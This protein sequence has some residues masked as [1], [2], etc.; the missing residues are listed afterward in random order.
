MKTIILV[1][2]IAVAACAKPGGGPLKYTFDNAKIASVP[3]DAKQSVTQAQQAHDEAVLLKQRASDGKR[4]SE[5]EADVAEYQAKR[6]QLVSQVV[7]L[8]VMEKPAQPSAE[9]AALARRAAEAKV[10]FARARHAWLEHLA[11]SSLFAAYAAQAK[12]ELERAKVAQANNLAPAG[13]D[14]NVFQQQAEKRAAAAARETAESTRLRGVA[15][16]RLA[17]WNELERGFMQ[18]SALVGPLESERVMLELKQW[19]QRPGAA[20]GL[21]ARDAM[22][23]SAAAPAPEGASPPE[24]ASPPQ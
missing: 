14:I 15:D 23:E 4:D 3:L 11:S 16:T 1:S 6:A 2:T 13:F 24:A 10:G 20:P 22:K 5:I 19:D 21:T 9:A 18:A 7:A 12:L 17:Q 8:R